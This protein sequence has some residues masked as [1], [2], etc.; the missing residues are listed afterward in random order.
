MKK[1]MIK[2]FVVILMVVCCGCL[3]NKPR[4]NFHGNITT[5]E[6]NKYR[7]SYVVKDA[8]GDIKAIIKYNKY[9]NSYIIRDTD[10]N[11]KA[12]IKKQK[13]NVR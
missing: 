1:M 5:I 4:S 7:D 3:A 11:I 6:Y 2:I 12:V 10:R 9:S 8:G 13:I